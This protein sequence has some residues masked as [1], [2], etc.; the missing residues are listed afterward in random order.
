M[1]SH[2]YCKNFLVRCLIGIL[3]CPPHNIFVLFSLFFPSSPFGLGKA[4]PHRS[5]VYLLSLAQLPLISLACVLTQRALSFYLSFN[6][7]SFNQPDSFENAHWYSI[8][9][10]GLSFMCRIKSNIHLE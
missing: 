1:L 10:D 4:K 6:D 9:E 2:N 3:F 8:K 5:R 7:F